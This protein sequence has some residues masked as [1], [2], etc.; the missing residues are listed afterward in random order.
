MSGLLFCFVLQQNHLSSPASHSMRRLSSTE[1]VTQIWSKSS[2]HIWWSQHLPSDLDSPTA[3]PSRG[4]PGCPN[5]SQSPSHSFIPQAYQRE[6]EESDLD[7]TQT[8]SCGL[9]SGAASLPH[10][11]LGTIYN[12]LISGNSLLYWTWV[13]LSLSKPV[14]HSQRRRN[15]EQRPLYQFLT[16]YFLY[17]SDEI[18]LQCYHIGGW[19]KPRN[20]HHHVVLIFWG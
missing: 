4:R 9:K 14:Y 11:P 3:A 12:T 15:T 17:S 8:Y 19:A 10:S 1:R 16:F 20:S 7:R 13:W 18:A 2:L 5:R 6:E